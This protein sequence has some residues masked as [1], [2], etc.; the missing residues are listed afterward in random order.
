[1]KTPFFHW[2]NPDP[3]AGWNKAYQLRYHSIAAFN[4]E[5]VYDDQNTTYNP[6]AINEF[7]LRNRGKWIFFFIAYDFSYRYLPVHP[8]KSL[9]QVP[10]V[11]IIATDDVV[12]N[13]QNLIKKKQN[14]SPNEIQLPQS[15]VDEHTYLKIFESLKKHIQ[16]GDIYEINYCI[17]FL[18]K[19]ELADTYHLWQYL[20]TYQPMP[21]SIYFTYG[22]LHIMSASPERFFTIHNSHIVSQPMKGTLRRKNPIDIEKEQLILK[23]N[24]KEQSENVMIVDL[25]RNDLSRIATKGS[26]NVDELF[27]VYTFPKVHQMISTIRATIKPETSFTAIMEALFPMG[28]MTGAPKIRAMQLISEYEPASRGAFSG[29][30]GYIDPQGNMDCSVLIRSIFYHS[31]E[32]KLTFS[33][34]SAITSQA[35][36]PEEYNECMLKASAIF[37]VLKS[38]PHASA[39]I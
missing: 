25:V 16:Q 1:M 4:A 13:D 35:S 12:V 32:K 27:G 8:A 14:K 20:I 7:I 24:P 28:S 30:L 10:S 5:Q 6:A 23:N 38:Y 11:I 36:G 3:Q 33:A 21:F 37:K 17:P 2:I 19:A 22:N 39:G 9:F 29:T 15:L 31:A 34:G 18:A 26:V